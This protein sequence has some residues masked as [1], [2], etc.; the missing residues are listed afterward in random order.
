MC[1]ASNAV[2]E[3]SAN[4]DEQ[5]LHPIVVRECSLRLGQ[6]LSLRQGVR[7]TETS[8]PVEQYEGSDTDTKLDADG[9]TSRSGTNGQQHADAYGTDIDLYISADELTALISVSR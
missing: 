5:G 3:C 6:G 1:D 2:G 7:G 9:K 8:D 4:G